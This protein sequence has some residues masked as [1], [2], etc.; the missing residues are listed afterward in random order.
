VNRTG[1]HFLA[2]AR[3]AEDQHGGV[4]RRDQFDPLHDRAQAG[5]DADDR[6]A[7]LFSTEPIQ[8]RTPVRF[9]GFAERG[10]LAKMLIVFQGDR[11][12]LQEFLGKREV[13]I[14][15]TAVDRRR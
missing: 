14:L 11:K 4:G 5:F 13:G 10:H 2:R 3:F 7:D 6:V 1:D 15:E 8:K 9:R 12:R